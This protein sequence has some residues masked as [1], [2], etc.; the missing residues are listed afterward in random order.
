MEKK[1]TKF[2]L[3]QRLPEF[4]LVEPTKMISYQK[5]MPPKPFLFLE[6]S[7]PI[8]RVMHAQ[9]SLGY[10]KSHAHQ[11][12]SWIC[13]ESCTPNQGACQNRKTIFSKFMNPIKEGNP[14][15]LPLPTY[16]EDS[17][18]PAKNLHFS[19]LSLV[20]ALVN[21]SEVIPSV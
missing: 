14:T 20:N 12:K 15:I 18:I 5:K 11:N 1:K 6:D 10:A 2:F 21:I 13:Q 8:P 3:N 7:K 17:A 16:V 9:P 19:C 4:L